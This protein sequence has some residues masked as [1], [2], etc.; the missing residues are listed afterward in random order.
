MI[1]NDFIMRVDLGAL[2]IIE[3]VI[4][5]SVDMNEVEKVAIS[6]LSVSSDHFIVSFKSNARFKLG[7]FETIMIFNEILFEIKMKLS[8]LLIFFLIIIY[9][10]WRFF[11]EIINKKK[12]K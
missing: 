3:R 2:L 11:F 8:R 9:L 1:S 5:L 12:S 4:N 7:A 6:S 10:F